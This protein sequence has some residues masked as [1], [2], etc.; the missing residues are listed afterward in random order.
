MSLLDKAFCKAL[1][2]LSPSSNFK[3]SLARIAAATILSTVSDGSDASSVD[4][5]DDIIF[6]CLPFLTFSGSRALRVVLTL[7][8]SASVVFTFLP[9]TILP[10]CKTSAVFAD[11]SVALL[12]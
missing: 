3:T 10:S 7:F 12:A 11:A 6:I 8:T 2:T 4:D 5:V 9:F 1:V